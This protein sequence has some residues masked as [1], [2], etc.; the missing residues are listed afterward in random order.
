[1]RFHD[2]IDPHKVHKVLRR[3]DMPFWVYLFIWGRL[4]EDSEPH[5]II[6]EILFDF[7]AYDERDEAPLRDLSDPSWRKAF[8][9]CA[10]KYEDSRIA[11]KEVIQ[12]IQESIKSYEPWRLVRIRV[13][14]VGTMSLGQLLLYIQNQAKCYFEYHVACGRM[15]TQTPEVKLEPIIDAYPEDIQ[16]DIILRIVYSFDE[17]EDAWI[18]LQLSGL[19]EKLESLQ[20]GRSSFNVECSSCDPDDKESNVR[21]HSPVKGIG[22]NDELRFFVFL[23]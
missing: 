2:P 7:K 23:D 22:I 4:K 1:M 17:G 21:I 15:P 11:T 8:A 18:P 9:D 3:H 20:E 5:R 14:M 10:A 13:E 12:E 19:M 6:S 16:G